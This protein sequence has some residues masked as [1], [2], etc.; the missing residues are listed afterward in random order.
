MMMYGHRNQGSR[1]GKA[2]GL[3]NISQ[4]YFIFLMLFGV[5]VGDLREANMLTEDT[6]EWPNGIYT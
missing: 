4:K 6:T 3:G 2:R 1:E 5:G